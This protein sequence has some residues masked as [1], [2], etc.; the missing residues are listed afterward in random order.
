MIVYQENDRFYLCPL[1]FNMCRIFT[2]LAVIVEKYG[3]KVKPL[4]TALISDRSL[5][6]EEPI[7]VTHTSYITFILNGVY[8]Y[9]QVDSNPFFPFYYQKIPIKAGKYSKD[10]CLD[11]FSK[12]WLFD[13][14]WGSGVSDTDIVK[15]ADLI[16]NSL[17][18]AEFSI[19]RR[20]SRR[21]K[22]DNIFN[23]GWHWENVLEPERFGDID[24]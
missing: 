22:V 12:S 3:G 18:K 21:K 13:Y 9:F 15:V 8:Y 7:V 4:K 16:F 11:E 2:A 19:I 17:V 1:D 5:K 14:L 20:E 10:V 6:G 23:S 24:F